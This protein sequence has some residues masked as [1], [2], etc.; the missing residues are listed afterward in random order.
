MKVYFCYIL[1]PNVY[2]PQTGRQAGR[3]TDTYRQTD[4]ETD[5]DSR[6]TDAESDWRRQTERDA[7]ADRDRDE[8]TAS[9]PPRNRHRQTDI[10]KLNSSSCLKVCNAVNVWAIP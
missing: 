9:Q 7:D 10:Q 4:R 3:D 8:Q 6:V 2:L 1:A 5:A